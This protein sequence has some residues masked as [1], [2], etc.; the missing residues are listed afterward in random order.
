[1]LTGDLDCRSRDAHLAFEAAVEAD[2]SSSQPAAAP[3]AG[4][5][6]DGNVTAG[7][8]QIARHG[9][10]HFHFPRRDPYI[11]VRAIRQD[12]SPAGC[13]NVAGDR[14]SDVD[15]TSRDDDVG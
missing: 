4:L 6:P 10:I 9:R 1:N 15:L 8:R 13:P 11:V 3:D 14:P 7:N 12:D 5:R 2:G